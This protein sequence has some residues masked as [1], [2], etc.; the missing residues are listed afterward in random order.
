LHLINEYDEENPT[1][2]LT[3]TYWQCYHG[4]HSYK[5]GGSLWLVWAG[6]RILSWMLLCRKCV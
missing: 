6:F 4:D 5:H 3:L 2:L 1:Y